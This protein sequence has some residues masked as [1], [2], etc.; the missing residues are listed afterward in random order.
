MLLITHFNLKVK[1][2]F[3]LNT[4]IIKNIPLILFL[5]NLSPKY[6]IIFFKKS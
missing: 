1:I 3:L 4:K 6:Y 5:E 2:L